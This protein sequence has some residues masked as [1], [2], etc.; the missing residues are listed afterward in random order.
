MILVYLAG[1]YR[2][3]SKFK[4]LNWLQRQININ[5]ARQASKELCKAGYAVICPHMN[6]ANFDGMC[7]DQFFL[8]A[9]LEMMKRCDLVVLL[10]N[11]HKSS[12]TINEVKVAKELKMP[13]YHLSELGY[14]LPK[15]EVK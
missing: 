2:G 10:P 8:D 11:W 5:N 9:T 1:P 13:I 7:P 14:G 6:T 3:K 4:P 12:G 15:L